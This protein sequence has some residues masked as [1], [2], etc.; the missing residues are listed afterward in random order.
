MPLRDL[1]LPELARPV[2]VDLDAVPVGVAEVD[3]LADEVVGRARQAHALAHRVGDPERE[4]APVRQQQREVEQPG[5]PGR[6]LRA[7]HLDQL[8]QARTVRR[9]ASR[10]RR[11]APGPSRPID[12]AVVLERALEIG[13]REMHGAHAGGRRRSA[14]SLRS[15]HA[16]AIQAASASRSPCTSSWP[17]G[18]RETC[19]SAPP[20]V[21]QL[22]ELGDL[23][24]A[25][26]TVSASPATIRTSVPASES[27]SLGPVGQHRSAAARRRAAG[28]RGGRAARRRCWRRSSSRARSRARRRARSA[29]RPPPPTRRAR[30]RAG[31]GRRGRDRR[32]RAARRSAAATPPSST[33]PRGLSSAASGASWRPRPIS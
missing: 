32:C 4:A 20:A 23:L 18:W 19:T 6:R 12:V 31:A 14:C 27:G 21:E 11:P 15:P 26:C 2:G 7:R 29:R 28:R 3:R 30:R 25:S 9:R 5:A 10:D 16:A 24:A 33:C 1:A 8:E 22:G 17:T 13:D